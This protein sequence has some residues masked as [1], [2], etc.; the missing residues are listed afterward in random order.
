M[1]GCDGEDGG[2]V[3]GEVGLGGSGGVAAPLQSTLYG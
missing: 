1:G 2:W 3:C